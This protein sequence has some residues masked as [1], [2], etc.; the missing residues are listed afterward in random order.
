MKKTGL[1]AALVLAAGGARAAASVDLSTGTALSTATLTCDELDYFTE[2]NRLEARGNAVLTSSGT[3]LRADALTLVP[4]A[5]TAEA[6]GRVIL[7]DDVLTLFADRVSYDWARS[8][9]SLRE[10]FIRQG[11]WRIW[12][13]EVERLG[14]DLF[15][16]RRAAFTSCDR[17]P[18]HYHFRG[19]S[20]VYRVDKRVS[21]SN[22]R[23]AL[24]KTPLL[25]IPFYA[26]SL[27]D[28]RWTLTVDPGNSARNG[29]TTKTIFSYPFGKSARASA[30]WDYFS[31]AGQGLGGEL[32]YTDP[33]ARGSLSAYMIRD[34]I[35]DDR[36]WNLRFAHWQQWSPRW[37]VQSNVAFQS[38]EEV[39]NTFVRDD[40]QRRRQLG[41]SDIAFTHTA[42]WFTARIVAEHDRAL[43]VAND[44]FVTARTVLPRLSAQTS[45]LRVGHSSLYFQGS[46][47]FESFYDRPEVVTGAPNPILPGKD[48][49][50]QTADSTA[51]LRWRWPLGKTISIEPSAGLTEQWHSHREEATTLDPRDLFQGR[52][53][54]GLNW[55]HRLTRALDYD[56][57]H[58]YQVR[59]RP[60]TWSRDHAATDAGLE[61]NEVS[62]FGSWRPSAAAWARLT[63]AYDFRDAPGLGYHT[64]RQRVSPPS[65]D[66]TLRPSRA[67]SATWRET[68]QLYPTRK[69]QSRQMSVRAGT[70]DRAYASSGISYNVGRPGQLDLN[71]GAA[72]SLTRGW[73]LSGDIHYTAE[74]G[75]RLRYNHMTFKEK[76]FVV[77]RDLHCWVVRVTY[78]ERPGVNELYFRLD[79]KTNAQWRASQKLAGEEQY[80]PARD[81][82]GDEE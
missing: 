80:Y 51:S 38:D 25:Y 49:V 15:R 20:A 37:Q 32:T 50:R 33:R 64:P 78:R 9:G 46:A 48:A 65:L 60:D 44:R 17:D 11:P 19:G 43:D 61:R 69:T 10:V 81:N 57:T 26:R 8:T 62:F 36:R 28:N 74:G 23:F 45:A 12:G 56:L 4:A 82:R 29:L 71:H 77:R 30:I 39:N 22:V 67:W 2:A 70:S 47:N 34:R 53:F 3:R 24:E 55:R 1:I 68:L 75:G 5:R 63:T 35:V 76:N 41:E 66:V 73:W 21:V 42:P 72:F 52:G 40:Y 31:R 6:A 54:T 18:P 27:Q 16:L 14:P 13:R 59:W 58:R 79:L 7:K